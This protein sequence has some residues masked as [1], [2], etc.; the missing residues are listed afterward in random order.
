MTVYACT[1][2]YSSRSPLSTISVAPA[3]MESL[4]CPFCSSCSTIS[5]AASVSGDCSVDGD[6]SS[7][8]SDDCC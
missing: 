7:S 1:I 5:S 2:N 3:T 8:I 4:F 6:G